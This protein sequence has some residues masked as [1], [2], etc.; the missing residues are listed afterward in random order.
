MKVVQPY[1]VPNKTK[2]IRSILRPIFRGI[3][4]LLSPISIIGMEH[5][6]AKGAYLIAANHVSLF[7]PPFLLAFWPTAPEAV[8]A[9]DLWSRPGQSILVRLYGSIPVHRESYD[10]EVIKTM[11]NVL[12]SGRPLLIAPEGRRSHTPGLQKAHPGVAYILDKVQVPVIPVG[13]SGTTDDYFTRAIHGKRPPIRMHIGEPLWLPK[14]SKKSVSRKEDLHIN[15][16]LIMSHVAALLPPEYRGF[17]AHP[18]SSDRKTQVG[19]A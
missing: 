18:D 3:F 19:D 9:V 17:Y 13:I 7:D 14:V 2:I 8:G 1:R 4:R 15:T 6:P 10:R 16:K 12:N 5:V 11:V